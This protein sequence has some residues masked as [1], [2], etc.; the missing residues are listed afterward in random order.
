LFVVA[1]G[2]DHLDRTALVRIHGPKPERSDMH[3]RNATGVIDVRT[4]P[5]WHEWSCELRIRYDGGQFTGNDVV[6]LL[7][8]V[9][10]QVGIGEGRPDSRQSAGLGFGLFRLQEAD[11]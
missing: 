1:D 7:S 4:R 6:N 8:R 11:E 2:Y 5:I 3:V 9:G 10:Q